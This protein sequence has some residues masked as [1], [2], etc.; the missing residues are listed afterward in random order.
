MTFDITFLSS[1]TQISALHW[2]KLFSSAQPFVRYA[3]LS[4]LEASGCVSESTGWQVSH[5]VVKTRENQAVVA[6][7]PLYI[8]S[9]SYGEYMFDWSWAKAYHQHG[10]NYY[11]KLVSAIPF[12]PV[13]GERL[14]IAD[15]FVKYQ[16]EICAQVTQA[17]ITKA[18]DIQAQTVQCLFYAQKG[19]AADM[20]K[21]P[22]WLKRTDIQF[23]WFNQAYAD[24]NEYLQ[25]MTA[26]KRKTINNERAKVQAQGIEFEWRSGLEMDEDLWA[27]F[28]RFYQAT[29]FKRSGHQGYLN[30]AFFALLSQKMADNILLLFAKHQGKIVAAALFFFDEH[31]LYGRYWGCSQEFDFLHFETC[32]YQG[33]EYCIKHQLQQFNAGAQG[34]HK[35][36]RGFS[37]VY[38]HGAY[39]ILGNV[40]N[41]AIDDFLQQEQVYQQQYYQQMHNKLPFKKR[42]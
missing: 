25:S 24:F 11:P 27:S 39:L 19:I 33:I 35:V 30:E 26:R 38:T 42:Q 31:S 1:I 9:H 32:Y 28:L 12:T 3:Y 16:L 21:Q 40:F 17:L 22:K 41:A 18:N 36:P 4:A 14:A 37:P 10:F 2:D 8:K 29:Y 13:A 7:M 20:A 34:E 6:V 5:L 23:H 15:S